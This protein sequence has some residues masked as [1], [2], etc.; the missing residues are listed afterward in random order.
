MTTITGYAAVGSAPPSI[1]ILNNKAVTRLST[2]PAVTDGQSR[3]SSLTKTFNMADETSNSTVVLLC[4][5]PA[6][7]KSTLSK[8]IHRYV[9][10]TRGDTIHVIYICYDDFIPRDLNLNEAIAGSQL[11]DKVYEDIAEEQNNS[12][13]ESN[14]TKSLNYSLWKHYR[15]LLLVTVDRLLNVIKNKNNEFLVDSF[16]KTSETDGLPSFHVFW[17]AFQENLSRENRNCSCF[18]PNGCR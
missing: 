17:N 10:K 7:G 6:S 8:E 9:Q 13:P 1:A 5:I 18:S 15:R 14:T 2:S 3:S 16:D 12:Q 4:G 11:P